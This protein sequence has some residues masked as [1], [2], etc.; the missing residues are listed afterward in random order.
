MTGLVIYDY[1]Y[2]KYIFE[3]C[4]CEL[5]CSNIYKCTYFFQEFYLIILDNDYENNIISLNYLINNLLVKE[6]FYISVKQS[7]CN[8]F[9]LLYFGN[10]SKLNKLIECSNERG[11]KIKEDKNKKIPYNGIY[12]INDKCLCNIKNCIKKSQKLFL[13]YLLI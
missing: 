1:K 7:K 12:I 4:K 13:D 3:K 2:S 6:L 8:C 10:N 11:L 5:I 9:D